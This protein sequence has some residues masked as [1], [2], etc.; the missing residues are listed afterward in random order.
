MCLC[1]YVSAYVF[2]CN[3]RARQGPLCLSAA[4][5]SSFI[6][7]ECIIWPFF[8]LWA[9]FVGELWMRRSERESYMWPSNSTTR[10][11]AV[12]PMNCV[13]VVSLVY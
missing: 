6:E 4:A 13:T 1:V 10:L 5:V 7:L 12:I 11:D 8:W 2:M 9:A 3:E